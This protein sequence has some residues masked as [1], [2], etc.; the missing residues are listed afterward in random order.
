MLH[1]IDI[2]I[3]NRQWHLSI[4]DFVLWIILFRVW[5]FKK[6]CKTE[7]D[8][9][10]WSSPEAIEGTELLMMFSVIIVI[11]SSPKKLNELVMLVILY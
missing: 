4:Q 6:C 1:Y 8:L 10:N 9:R 7:I 11:I 2:V 5:K 3:K